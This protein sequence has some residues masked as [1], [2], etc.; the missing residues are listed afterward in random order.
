MDSGHYQFG[1]DRANRIAEP[2]RTRVRVPAA[3]PGRDRPRDVGVVRLCE[4]GRGDAQFRHGREDSL[5]DRGQ[6]TLIGSHPP[7]RIDQPSSRNGD[8]TLGEYARRMTTGF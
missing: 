4:H 2:R 3:H 5:R 7:V 1:K 8:A 6:A